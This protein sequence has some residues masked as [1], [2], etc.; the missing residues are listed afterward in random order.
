LA[1]KWRRVALP[2]EAGHA[3]WT[4]TVTAADGVGLN[5]VVMREYKVGDPIA[6]VKKIKAL[7][8]GLNADH[9]QV[10]QHLTMPPK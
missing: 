2:A 7:N 4:Y 10:G 5:A 9:I 6:L 1:D 3:N 8:P